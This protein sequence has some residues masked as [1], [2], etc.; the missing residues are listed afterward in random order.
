MPT[1]NFLRKKQHKLSSIQGYAFFSAAVTQFWLDAI[2]DINIHSLKSMLDLNIIFPKHRTNI[3][4]N[5]M[6]ASEKSN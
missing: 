5:A 4:P 2:P 1:R 3:N 6:T